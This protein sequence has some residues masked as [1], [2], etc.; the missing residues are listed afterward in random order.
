MKRPRWSLR[1]SLLLI[2]ALG[3]LMGIGAWLRARLQARADAIE[4]I[5]RRHGTYGIRITGPDWYRR[6]VLRLGGDDRMFYDPIR[7]SVG[8]P[9]PGYDPTRPIRD[10]DLERLAG[11]LASFTNL[12]VIDIRDPEVSDRGIAALPALPR[13]MHL[14]LDGSGV[15]DDVVGPLDKFPTLKT[16]TLESTRVTKRGVAEIR[17]R[18]PNCEVE[19]TD[20]N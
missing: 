1:A 6:L 8:P 18:H 5:D 7:V 4:A 19:W 11:V 20:R 14:R 12:E 10:D 9:T 13:L 2:A 3:V 15:T 17:R 16:L